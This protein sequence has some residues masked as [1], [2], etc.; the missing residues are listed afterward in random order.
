MKTKIKAYEDDVKTNF[1]KKGMLKEGSSC[2]CLSLII[3]E[4]VIK[5]GKKF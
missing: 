3:L 2:K 1:Q 5:T 4:S